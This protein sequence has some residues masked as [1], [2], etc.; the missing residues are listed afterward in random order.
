MKIHLQEKVSPVRC[1]WTVTAVKSFLPCRCCKWLCF[2]DI[3]WHVELQMFL[4]LKK[5]QWKHADECAKF[6]NARMYFEFSAHGLLQT[7]VSSHALITHMRSKVTLVLTKRGS[8]MLNCRL[9]QVCVCLDRCRI[10]EWTVFTTLWG[11]LHIFCHLVCICHNTV[12]SVS[13]L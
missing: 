1:G 12:G 11:F 13:I 10:A 3:L 4:K 7:A 5:T 9:Q 6:D 8:R 2:S